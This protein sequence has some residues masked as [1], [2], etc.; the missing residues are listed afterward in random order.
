MVKMNEVFMS[1]KNGELYQVIERLT[2]HELS[3]N[4]TTFILYGFRNIKDR[5]FYGYV[6]SKY[7]SG[8]FAKLGVEQ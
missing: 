2:G 6:R 4:T 7:L 5:T 8:H 3:Q 1:R